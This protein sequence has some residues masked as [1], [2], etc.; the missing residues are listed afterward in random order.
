MRPAERRLLISGRTSQA[1][2]RWKAA[3]AV[4]GSELVGGELLCSQEE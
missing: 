1:L 2:A 3:F 4:V